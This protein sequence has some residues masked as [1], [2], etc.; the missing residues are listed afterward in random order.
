MQNQMRYI[1]FEVQSGIQNRNMNRV[2]ENKKMVFQLYPWIETTPFFL[3]SKHV[4]PKETNFSRLKSCRATHNKK[5]PSY[6]STSNLIT[7]WTTSIKGYH[8]N[9]I[10]EQDMNCICQGVLHSWNI[11]I[12]TSHVLLEYVFTGD[13]RQSPKWNGKTNGPWFL[14]R[15]PTDHEKNSLYVF[16]AGFQSIPNRLSAEDACLFR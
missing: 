4:A 3:Y 1:H 9:E 2:I 11:H 5:N 15:I 13:K 14:L 8:E 16:Q 6:I 12:W 10:P 7:T